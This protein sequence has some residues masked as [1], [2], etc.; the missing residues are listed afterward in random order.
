MELKQ[1][2][3]EGSSFEVDE[4]FIERLQAYPTKAGLD[5]AR[6]LEINF[7]DLEELAGW[8]QRV[9]GVCTT[10]DEPIYFEIEYLKQPDESPLFLDISLIEVDDYLD[11]ILENKT[12]KFNNNE[13]N[14]RTMR[15][16]QSR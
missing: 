7:D 6:Q 8:T 3:T 4:W 16:R 1:K 2:Y 11:Y 9:G 10:L 15:N 13:T 12:L 5:V 14:S